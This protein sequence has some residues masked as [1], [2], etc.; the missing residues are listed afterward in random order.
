MVPKELLKPLLKCSEDTSTSDGTPS[1]KRSAILKLNGELYRLKGCGNLDEGFPVEPMAW[2]ENS[3]EVRG[4]QFKCTVFREL[5]YQQKI[6]QIMEAN[7]LT[8][9]NEPV[10]AWHYADDSHGVAKYC[11]L[12]KTRGDLR[13]GTNLYQG[14]LQLAD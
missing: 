14:L 9:G 2:P 1:G 3:C 13:L 4:C 6:N 12:F 10:G 5:F 7:Q 8:G 11:G